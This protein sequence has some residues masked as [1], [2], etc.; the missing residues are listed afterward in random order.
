LQRPHQLW[1]E[2]FWSD[3][4]RRRGFSQLHSSPFFM[5]SPPPTLAPPADGARGRKSRRRLDRW[6]GGE[7]WA[8]LSADHVG[9]LR[10]LPAQ[11]PEGLV[12][13]R[14]QQHR[15][16]GN[17]R[18]RAAT[19]QEETDLSEQIARPEPRHGHT[20]LLDA[21]GALDDREQLVREVAWLA[22]RSLA[23]TVTSSNESA[24]ATRT[25]GGSAARQG[26]DST[27]ARSTTS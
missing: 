22:T 26:I 20:V 1:L 9:E 23:G 4:S 13:E 18:S 16:L 7:A 6:G 27:R 21:R 25:A 24:S 5:W 3:R 8:A 10:V 15:R 11:P 19:G 17:D 14:E 2:P 12:E